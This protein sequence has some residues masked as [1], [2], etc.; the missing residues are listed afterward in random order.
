MLKNV[1][2]CISK[3]FNTSIHNVKLINKLQS[4][5]ND[6]Y[7]ISINNRLYLMKIS[8]DEKSLL[9]ENS[10]L[11]IINRKSYILRCE[12]LSILLC[13]WIDGDTPCE[14]LCNS[15][16]F[17]YKLS[18]KLKEFHSLTPS[19]EL[20]CI[21]PFS[22]INNKL[23]Y[24]KDKNIQLPKTYDYYL[25]LLNYIKNKFPIKNFSLCH[26]DLNP[27]NIIVSN[28]N[29]LLIDFEF[30]ALNDIFFDLA[31][32]SLFIDDSKKLYFL[33]SYLGN[34]TD[35]DIEKLKHYIKLVKLYNGLWS[36]TKSPSTNKNYDYKK[37]GFLMLSSI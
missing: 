9:K 5:S 17:I 30:S 35:Y 1:F 12:N 25:E 20:N 19:K 15:N 8:L 14:Y 22:Y 16:E 23:S 11:K 31:T 18:I 24:C 26:N 13:N 36:I 4:L 3:K 2:L 6:A 27:S 7:N 28:N 34:I 10:I 37:G 33:K 21:S 29:P 32:Y